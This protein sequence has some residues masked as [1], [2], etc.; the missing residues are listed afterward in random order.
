ML[1]CFIGTAVLQTVR[2]RAKKKDV[3]GELHLS[4]LL[5]GYGV[6]DCVKKATK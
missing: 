1:C 3:N 5:L 6:T 2:L 4:F